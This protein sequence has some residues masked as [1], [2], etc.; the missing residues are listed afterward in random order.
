LERKASTAWARRA[1]K[2]QGRKGQ[3]LHNGLLTFEG[4]KRI[5]Q[6]RLRELTA[7]KALEYK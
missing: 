3:S 6:T 5:L 4:R 1:P 2:L 7:T